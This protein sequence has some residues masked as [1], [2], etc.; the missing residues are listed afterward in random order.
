MNTKWMWGLWGLLL[1]PSAGFAQP[2]KGDFTLGGSVFGYYNGTWDNT[3]ATNWGATVSPR[4][5]VF[6]NEHLQLG[7]TFSTSYSQ[8]TWDEGANGFQNQRISFGPEVAYYFGDKRWTP[9]VHGTIQFRWS[10]NYRWREGEEDTQSSVRNSF[11]RLGGGIAYWL[12]P[13]VAL[14]A[15]VNYSGLGPILPTSF[16]TEYLSSRIGVLFVWNRN[17]SE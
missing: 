17:T 3:G 9:F 8:G 12:A 11:T 1:L 14:Q 4:A 7:S 5:G 13:K 2:Q 6:L 15:S 16:G 10:Q